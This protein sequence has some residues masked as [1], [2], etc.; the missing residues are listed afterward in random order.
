MATFFDTASLSDLDMLHSSIRDH[1]ELDNVVNDVEWKIID[2]YTQRKGLNRANHADFFRY[3]DGNAPSNEI[4]VRLVGYDQDIPADSEAALKA[5]LK[6]AIAKAAS[7]VLRNY[8][9]PQGVQSIRQGQRSVTYGIDV[10]D[11]DKM[12]SGIQ[13]ILKNHDA[14]IAAYG[15]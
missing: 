10:P 4:Q 12:P 9:V 5:Q 6:R 14:R 11:W 7:W 15:I 2:H 8:E 3:E 1:A 13:A